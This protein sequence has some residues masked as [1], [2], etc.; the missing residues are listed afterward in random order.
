MLKGL[1]GRDSHVADH[2][3]DVGA[4]VLRRCIL[5]DVPR[6]AWFYI[7]RRPE[8]IVLRVLRPGLEEPCTDQ[9]A[10]RVTNKSIS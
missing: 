8:R 3:V 1:R 4:G 10:R 2:E 7:A 6:P 5:P 9:R